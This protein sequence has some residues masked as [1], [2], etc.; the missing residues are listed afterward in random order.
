MG[1]ASLRW[2]RFTAF[3]DDGRLCLT[4]DGV[5]KREASFSRC[6]CRFYGAGWATLQPTE[7]LPRKSAKDLDITDYGNAD[8]DR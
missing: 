4:T 1:P 2:A 8:H 6:L 5:A 3:L 7:P